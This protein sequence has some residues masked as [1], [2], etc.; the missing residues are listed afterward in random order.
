MRAFGEVPREFARD[1]LTVW[2]CQPR[3][4]PAIIGASFESRAAWRPNPSTSRPRPNG[5]IARDE[6]IP[7]VTPTIVAF[8]GRTERGPLNE[9]VA[10]KS[11]DDYRRVFGGIASFSFVSFAVQHFFLH[12]GEAAVVVRVAESCDPRVARGA[13]RRRRAAAP[14]APAGQ[15]R[16]LARVRRLR[17]RRA[18]AGPLQ[19]RDPA[20][21]RARLS[22]RR[23][24]GAVRIV[25][26]GRDA[27]S[28][29]SST[30]CTTRSSCGSSGRC[31]SCGRTR[32]VL[33]APASRFRISPP[34]RPEPT[35]RSSPITT[36]SAPTP[37]ARDL[38]ALDRC[39]QVDLVCV[40]SPPG[41]D[42]GSTSFVAATRYCERRRAL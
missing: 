16:V 37:K 27:T 8:I 1:D 17:P 40:P 35:A 6:V 21:R 10:L 19:S 30:R 13:G 24:P 36:S 22:A 7:L 4:G 12:G 39:E 28:A 11:F 18:F 2:D 38:F 26:D 33:R 42:L 41:R 5:P 20:P 14:G 29:S 32:R 31:R 34:P 3:R 25:V 23:R 9:P 15:P